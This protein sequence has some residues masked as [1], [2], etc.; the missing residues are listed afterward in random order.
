MKKNKKNNLPILIIIIILFILLILITVTLKVLLDSEKK[1]ND[2]TNNFQNVNIDYNEKINLNENSNH[3]LKTVKEVIE[4]YGSQYLHRLKDGYVEIYINSKY[5]LFDENGKSKE[6]YF[7]NM[8]NEIIKIEKDS[9]YLKDEF[10]D[11]SIYVKYNYANGTYETI[12]NGNENYYDDVNADIYAKVA[13]VT[14]PVDSD[15][16]IYN[17]FLIQILSN[18]TYYSGT[19][20][21]SLDRIDLGNNYYSYE[22]GKIVALLK[23][24]KALN[25]LLKKDYQEQIGKNVYVGTPLK[26]VY[27]K[28][29]NLA[30]GSLKERYL[31]YKISNAY[32]F[33]YEDEISIYGHEYK[34]N[35][36]I[37]QYIVDYCETGDLK[38]LYNDF[39]SGFSNYFENEYNPENE[40]LKLTFPTR[41]IEIDIKDNDSKGIKIYNNYYISDKIKELILNEKITLINEN[42]IYITEQARRESMR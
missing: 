31:A 18:Y 13:S 19:E 33:L 20:L 22:N 4:F 21:S 3:R 41:G 29:S 23:N 10:K 7:Y 27:E 26:E 1:V 34:E 42:F 2:Y 16:A 5:D 15:F 28:Y 6:Q 24:G 14:S 35:K 30:F 36:Y 38:K 9:F 8:I 37:D 12:I 39:M 25:I 11:I 32:V 17:N 40:S